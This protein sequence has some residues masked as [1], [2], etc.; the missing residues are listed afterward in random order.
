MVLSDYPA[1]LEFE[2]KLPLVHTPNEAAEIFERIFNDPNYA[3][4]LS[5]TSFAIADERR[6]DKVAKWYLETSP[7]QDYNAPI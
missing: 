5:E 3:S 6:W 7:R 4:L 1:F 2:G